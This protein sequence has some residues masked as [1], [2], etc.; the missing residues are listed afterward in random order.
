MIIIKTN[1]EGFEKKETL[2][3][4]KNYAYD[5]L[6][7]FAWNLIVGVYSYGNKKSYMIENNVYSII[8]SKNITKP[9]E[10]DII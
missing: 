7:G 5:R 1:G 2:Q 3:Y 9:F 10:D 6:D 8:L 4:L